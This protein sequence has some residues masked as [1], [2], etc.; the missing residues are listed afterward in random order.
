MCINVTHLRAVTPRQNN[1]NR[2]GAQKNSSTGVRGVSWDKSRGK[3]IAG[4][5]HKGV[6]YNLGRFDSIKEAE[7]KVIAKRKELGFLG[8]AP[9][10]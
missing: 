9:A 5:K 8:D 1:Q 7:M 6:R 4:V 10:A 2:R 3:Y